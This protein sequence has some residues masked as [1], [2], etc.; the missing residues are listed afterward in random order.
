MNWGVIGYGEITP[1]F[2]EGVQAS[3]GGVLVGIASVSSHEMLRKK[4]LYGNVK[5]YETYDDLI[6]SSEVE[7]VYISTTNDLHFDNAKLVLNAGKHLL[8]EKPLTPTNKQT[9]ELINI[10][11]KN[12]VFLMEGMWTRFLPAYRKLIE[13][14]AD[15]ILGD[16]KLLKVDFGFSNNWPSNRRLLNPKL[17][18]GTLLDNADYNIFLSQDVFKEYP[19]EIAAQATFADTGVE[20]ACSI[21]LKYPS[22]GLAQ[23][24]STFRCETKQEAVIYGENGY[25]EFKE[26]WHGTQ[27][28]RNIGGKIETN[29]YRYSANGFECQIEAVEKSILQ[30]K[31]EEDII[32]H[33]ASLEVATIIDEVA[34]LINRK[35]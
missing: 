34:S 12:N 8:C 28:V 5:I 22:G 30:G 35:R 20:D 33:F 32:P 29:D 9:S 2:I 26:Y 19:I 7:I 21:L 3:S 15:R 1:S 6:K 10:A 25:I 27:I 18:G 14:L 23:L 31:V 13:L 11:K 17:F 24:F 16:I 4:R